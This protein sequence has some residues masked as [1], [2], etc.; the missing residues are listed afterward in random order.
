MNRKKFEAFKKWREKRRLEQITEAAY[1]NDSG[2]EDSQASGFIDGAQW[3][4]L[5][6]CGFINDDEYVDGL[7][8][9]KDITNKEFMEILQQFPEDALISIECCNPRAMMYDEKYNLIR[10]D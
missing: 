4:D 10:I 9:R 8:E 2:Y 7:L 3:A 6:P 5:H 1:H